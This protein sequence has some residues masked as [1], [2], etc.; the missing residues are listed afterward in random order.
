MNVIKKISEDHD[1]EVQDWC[2]NMKSKI[3]AHDM[4]TTHNI[5]VSDY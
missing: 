1:M 5:S 3:P 4:T 2:A